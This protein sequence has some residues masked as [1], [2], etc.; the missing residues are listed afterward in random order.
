LG[1]H[2]LKKGAL[3]YLVSDEDPIS[4]DG[5]EETKQ[6]IDMVAF[7]K[8]HL[9][10]I[11]LKETDAKHRKGIKFKQI[12]R[13]YY[14]CRDAKYKIEFWVFVYWKEYG[15]ITG[16]KVDRIENLQFYAIDNKGGLQFFASIGVDPATRIR[17][18]VDLELKVGATDE[19]LNE[20]VDLL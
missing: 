16:V 5:E 17:K 7:Y 14:L 12:E 8:D 10:V 19:P 13:Y 11:E 6:K 18:K 15:L 1:K 4:W 3:T 2:L 20:M 9:T